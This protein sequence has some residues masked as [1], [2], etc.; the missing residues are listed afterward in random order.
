M[1]TALGFAS[2][3]GCLSLLPPSTHTH[4]ANSETRCEGKTPPL[5]HCPTQTQL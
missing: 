4:T 1:E 2:P 3:T 5:Q